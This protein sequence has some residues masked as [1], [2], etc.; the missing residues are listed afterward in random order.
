MLEK[1]GTITLTLEDLDEFHKGKVSDKIQSTWGLS[2]EDLK[3]IVASNDYVPAFAG[4]MFEP[5]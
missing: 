4:R 3:K 5:K 1:S 2:F